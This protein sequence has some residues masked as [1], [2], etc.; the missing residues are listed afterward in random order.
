MTPQVIS[1]VAAAQHNHLVEGFDFH[2]VVCQ[3]FSPSYKLKNRVDIVLTD[4]DGAERDKGA[5]VQD[6]QREV[7][8]K[9]R[10]PGAGGPQSVCWAYASG[11][12]P[13][14][15]T[16]PRTRTGVSNGPTWS[17]LMHPSGSQCRI[18]WS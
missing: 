1:L 16:S 2:M 17:C 18:M 8:C 13:T 5:I 10:K 12:R 9:V 4:W 6:D 14:W 7:P 11:Q 3:V 15:Q